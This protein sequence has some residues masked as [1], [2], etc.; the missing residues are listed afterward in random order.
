MSENDDGI[1]IDCQP[2]NRNEEEMRVKMEGY[3]VTSKFD[4]FDKTKIK[5]FFKNPW[6][7]G[8]ILFLVILLLFYI[9]KMLM[10][11]GKSQGKADLQKGGSKISS[12]SS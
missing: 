11:K 3:K 12:D 7:Q 2:V 4:L 5:N 9:V 8:F 10:A 1:Y 6:V